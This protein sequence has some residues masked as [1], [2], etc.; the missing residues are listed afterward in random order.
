MSLPTTDDDR[1]LRTTD[2]EAE[3]W[4]LADESDVSEARRAYPSGWLWLTGD[5]SIRALVDALRDADTDARYGTDDLAEMADRTPEAVDSVV[6]SL[7]SLGVLFADEGTYRVNEHSVVLHAVRK[8]SAAVEATGAPD[9]KSG[10]RHLSRLDSVRVMVDA[11]VSADPDRSL[12]Q[13]D[14]H[15]LTGVS[16]K[17]VW[18]HVEQLVEL[19]V[20]EE[21]GDEYLLVQDS[22]VL[23]WVQSADAAVVGAALAASHP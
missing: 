8:L 3:M 12:T 6:D 16:R 4:E 7:I 15:R 13:E 19:S 14:V 5:E 23:R 20:L 18:I 1:Q 10:F 21:S 9:D 2:T 22:P 17:A 11:L